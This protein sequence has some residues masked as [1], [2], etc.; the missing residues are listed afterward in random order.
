MRKT[1]TVLM[2]TG[3]TLAATLG[4]AG[5]ADAAIVTSQASLVNGQ[6]TIV[7]SGAVP[8]GTVS[9]DDG[10]TFG[11]VDAQGNFSIS[12][13]GFSEPS[14]IATLFDGSVSVEVTL[15]GCTPTISR[16]PAVPGVPTAVAPPPRAS[17]T[18]PVALSWQPPA[19]APAV[20]F[21]WQLSAHPSFRRIVLTAT[22]SPKITSTTLSG[23]AAGTYFWRVQAVS[24]PPSPFFPLFGNWTVMRS[25]TITGETHR[26]PGTPALQAPAPGTE[27]HPEETFPLTWTAVKHAVSYRLQLARNP[28]FAPGKVLVDVPE[29]TTTAHAP[30]FGFQTPLFV[31]VFGVARDG[32]LGL[33]SPTVALNITFQAPV[34]PAPSP[35]APADGATVTLPVKLSWT[36]DPNPQIPGYQL[37]ISKTR[38]FAGGCGGVEEC[39]TG[40]SQPN[41]TLF[42]LPP[43]V[44]Y[45]RARSFQGLSGPNRE[46]VTAWSAARSFTVSNAPPVVRGLTVDVFTGGGTF[47]RSHT[48]VFSG[49]NEDNEAFGIVQLSTPAP[50]GGVSVTLASSD[51]AV[52][53]MRP[54]VTI[55]AGHAQ[56]SFR[57]RPQQVTSPATATL[58]ASLGGQAAT[59]R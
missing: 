12:A 1:I 36:P 16:P 48:H 28:T 21:R 30:L 13:S 56:A 55:V 35:L 10:P 6:L 45:W 41:D 18:E 39:V 20:S 2:V 25:L 52:A 9:V 57:I 58:S 15:S 34:P 46:A 17:V 5:P 37:E 40:L 32:S 49:T 14:C 33:P 47:L 19:G 8:N 11:R 54:S 26:T 42:S 3:A 23:L 53:S 51:P 4:V 31:R 27:F 44:H 59:A 50:A 43:G 29:S 7:G 24:F 38:N 22:T